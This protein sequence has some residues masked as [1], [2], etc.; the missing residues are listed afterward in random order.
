MSCHGCARSFGFLTKE[1]GCEKCGFSFC[2]KCLVKK[3]CKS[4]FVK[5]SAVPPPVVSQEKNGKVE[6]P[7]QNQVTQIPPVVLEQKLEKLENPN[8]SPIVVYTEDSRMTNLKKGLSFEDQQLVNRL[9][10]LKSEIRE[11]KGDIPSQSEIEER[12]AKLKGIDPEVYRK[13]AAIYV[14]PKTNNVDDATDLINQIREEVAIDRQS[15]LPSATPSNQS[16]EQTDDVEMLLQNEAQAIQADAQLALEGL[17]KDREIQERLNKL[18]FDR[19]TKKPEAKED[20]SSDEDSEDEDKQ[21]ARIINRV[22]DEDRLELEDEGICDEGVAA[23]QEELPWCELCNGDAHLRC[24]D[25]DGDLYCRRC[26]KEIHKDA[27][28]KHHRTENYKA[29]K[30]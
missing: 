9:S 12:L 18:R 19:G 16:E 17:K 15:D 8:K 3:I 27:D 29:P 1:Y 13:P 20:K 2:S 11:M 6:T 14:K 23:G 26:W 10:K 28:L 24:F 22:L 21:A 4:C 5:Q 7:H 25:C 30:K